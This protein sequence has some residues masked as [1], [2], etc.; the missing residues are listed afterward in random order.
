[1]LKRIELNIPGRVDRPVL[2]EE[3]F[4]GPR[5]GLRLSPSVDSGEGQYQ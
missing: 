5:A 3:G 1:M 4:L 2:R